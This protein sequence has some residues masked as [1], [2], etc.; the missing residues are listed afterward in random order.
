MFRLL[1]FRMPQALGAEIW[2]LKFNFSIVFWFWGD[3]MNNT[4]M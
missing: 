4:K 2:V 3:N 1:L